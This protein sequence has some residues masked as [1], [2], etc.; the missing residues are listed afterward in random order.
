MTALVEH[1]STEIDPFGSEYLADP[2]RFHEELRELGPVIH[3]DRYGAYACARYDEIR[4]VLADPEAY[5]SAAGTGIADISVGGHWR[6][7]SILLENAP[8]SHTR[9][10]SALASVLTPR[11]IRTLRD[12]FTSRAVPLIENALERSEIDGVVDLARVF[13]LHAFPDAVGLTEDRRE[14]LL[15]YGRMVFD[16]MGPENDIYRSVMANAGET[17]AWISAQCQ[18][19]ALSPNG[20]GA[21]VFA[22]VDAG[23]LTEDEGALVVRSFLSAGVDTTVHGIAST[24]Y[25]LANDPDQYAALRDDPSL[26]RW[27]FE[28]ALRL[29]APFQQFFRTTTRDVELAGTVIP[30]ATKVLVVPASANRDPRRWERPTEFDVRRRS[31]GHLAFGHGIH[32]CVGQTI[33][34]LEAEVLL[35]ELICRVEGISLTADPRWGTSN[36]LRGL[37]AL[38]IELR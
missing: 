32:A 37:E 3:L 18:R 29:E 8:P 23:Q 13:P 17:I 1:A 10:R 9:V 16:A 35:T 31:V 34:R 4:A 25:C 20:L 27:A 30:A 36:T 38:P 7:P 21:Q 33:A 11:N 26:V 15:D 14:L 2:Y 12:H 19:E 6:T 5:T 24:L 28:E 22:T